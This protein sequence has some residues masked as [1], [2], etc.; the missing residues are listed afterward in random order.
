MK[1]ITFILLLL[2]FYKSIL[3]SQT[4][5]SLSV[6]ATPNSQ[7]GW[8]YFKNPAIINP[9]SVFANYKNAFSLNTD[10]NMQIIKT[11]TDKQG[12]THTYYQQ[13]FKGIK[14]EGCQYIIHSKNS[15]SYLANGKTC[16]GLSLSITPNVT[17]SN[18]INYAKAFVNATKYMWEDSTEEHSL[19][20]IKNDRSA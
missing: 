15:E 9:V 3:I 1:K 13:Y 8:V 18:A 7:N 16:T 5:T 19:K 4:I 14:V 11:E 17:A 2:F 6:I 10:D 12:T 20:E